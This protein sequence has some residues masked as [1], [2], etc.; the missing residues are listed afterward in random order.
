M[1]CRTRRAIGY[2]IAGYIGEAGG[3]G[4]GECEDLKPVA[5][6]PT[7]KTLSART[8]PTDSY[9]MGNSVNRRI[10]EDSNHTEIVLELLLAAPAW[11]ADR[12]DTAER[13]RQQRC[14]KQ[15]RGSLVTTAWRSSIAASF[16]FFLLYSYIL[17][18]S[19]EKDRTHL[20]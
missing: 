11:R 20:S 3:R 13:R 18:H 17:L 15:R 8:L 6:T 16:A 2:F 14:R 7:S 4:K 1:L 12:S 19:I 10:Y 9:A 5:I